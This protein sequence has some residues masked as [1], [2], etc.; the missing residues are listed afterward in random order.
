MAEAPLP[1]RGSITTRI[2][3]RHT[4]HFTREQVLEAL[5]RAAGGG[6]AD[7]ATVSTSEYSLGDDIDDGL[8]VTWT[9]V[10]TE[11]KEL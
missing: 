2:E 7:N 10:Y 4:Q 9:T 3:R 1:S 5:N 6:I 11:H 8:W